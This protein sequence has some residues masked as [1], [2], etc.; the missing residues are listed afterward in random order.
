[1]APSWDGKLGS[2]DRCSLEFVFIL[3]MVFVTACPN[4]RSSGR[5]AMRLTTIIDMLISTVVHTAG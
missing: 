1:M 3:E 5:I 2:F 4:R